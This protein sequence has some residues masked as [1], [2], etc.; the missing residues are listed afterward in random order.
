MWYLSTLKEGYCPSN[1]RDKERILVKKQG[2]EMIE[3]VTSPST[4]FPVTKGK[5]HV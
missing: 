3:L 1:C 2:D 5:L 4:V